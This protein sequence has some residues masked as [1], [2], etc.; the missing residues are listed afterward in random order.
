MMSLQEKIMRITQAALLELDAKWRNETAN[1]AFS[2]TRTLSLL[3]G[4]AGIHES[5]VAFVFELIE[6][7]RLQLQIGL[8]PVAQPPTEPHADSRRP[9]ESEL[10]KAK[11]DAVLHGYG[12]TV[13]GRRVSPVRV[14][15]VKQPRRRQQS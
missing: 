15:F 13:D 8:T 9:D 6:S 12:I 14:H 1:A 10:L 7:G 4:K 5:D 3:R 2:D 11:A